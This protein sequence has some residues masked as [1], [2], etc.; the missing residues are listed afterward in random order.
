MFSLLINNLGCNQKW[1]DKKNVPISGQKLRQYKFYF[2][3]QELE[4]VNEYRYLGTVIKT[5]GIIDIKKL[6]HSL[7]CYETKIIIK[8]DKCTDWH[9][10]F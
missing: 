9:E 5:S 1:L 7:V 8:R 2:K 4:I 3:E 10:A 6:S